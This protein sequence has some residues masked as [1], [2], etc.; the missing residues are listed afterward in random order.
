M[1]CF[2]SELNRKSWIKPLFTSFHVNHVVLI[3]PSFIWK[4]NW[5]GNTWSNFSLQLVYLR[6]KL[7]KEAVCDVDVFVWSELRTNLRFSLIQS[8]SLSPGS[9][10]QF[11]KLRVSMEPSMAWEENTQNKY[12]NHSSAGSSFHFF[13]ALD[14]VSEV[15]SGSKLFCLFHCWSASFSHVHITL[16]ACANKQVTRKQSLFAQINMKSAHSRTKTK[17]V[18]F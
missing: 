5:G 12:Q 4:T 14:K 2:S 3:W 1:C 11:A 7:H 10:I 13:S 9:S 18:L 8:F 17:A 15:S 6:V 16:S